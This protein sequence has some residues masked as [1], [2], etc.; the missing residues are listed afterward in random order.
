MVTE[1]GLK[2]RRGGG[3]CNVSTTVQLLYLFFCFPPLLSSTCMSANLTGLHIYEC[4][5]NKKSQESWKINS[6]L[7]PQEEKQWIRRMRRRSSD[8][9]SV[10]R[11]PKTFMVQTNLGVQWDVWLLF[12]RFWCKRHCLQLCECSLNSLKVTFIVTFLLYV[13]KQADNSIPH[14]TR[15]CS[16]GCWPRA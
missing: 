7:H 2:Q 16:T 12:C 4:N 15:A 9:M 5:L 8:C 10:W 3:F 6:F 13:F 11:T 14:L 1:D